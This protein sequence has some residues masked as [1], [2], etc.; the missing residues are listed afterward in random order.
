MF[1]KSDYWET[2]SKT[3]SLVHW[4]AAEQAV[5]FEFGKLATEVD[6]EGEF[7]KGQNPQSLQEFD[8]AFWEHNMSNSSSATALAQHHGLPTRLLDWTDDPIKAAFFACGTKPAEHPH[9]IAIWALRIDEKHDLQIQD[10]W[11]RENKTARPVTVVRPPRLGNLFLKAQDGLLTETTDAVLYYLYNK[12][13]PA[14][15]HLLTTT[16]VEDS[17]PHLA[18]DGPGLRKYVLP[19]SEVNEFAKLLKREGVSRSKLM[20]TLD[21]V[22][23]EVKEQIAG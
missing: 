16:V 10:D 17:N 8:L 12:Q 4:V 15:D 5:L 23:Y 20:P 1:G 19:A 2:L 21:N 22:A 18:F 6:L 13:W 7:R 14:L 3:P 9:D 11:L